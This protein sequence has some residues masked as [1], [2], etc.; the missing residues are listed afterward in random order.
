M[1][2]NKVNCNTHTKAVR[3]TYVNMPHTKQKRLRHKNNI[4]LN[5]TF[6]IENIENITFNLAIL[7]GYILI[8]LF[9]IYF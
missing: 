9:C 5:Q 6:N 7:I 4:P 3:T 8:I 2:K 1:A